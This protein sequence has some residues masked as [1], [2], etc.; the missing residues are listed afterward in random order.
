MPS[1]RKGLVGMLVF[2]ACFL[3]LCAPSHG[4]ALQPGYGLAPVE[5]HV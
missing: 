3:G 5:L 2:L 1:A 4:H